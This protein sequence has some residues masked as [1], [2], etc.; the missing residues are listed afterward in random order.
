M[1]LALGSL[2]PSFKLVTYGLS[3]QLA[4]NGLSPPYHLNKSTVILGASGMMFQF[5]GVT[6]WATLFAHV[7]VVRPGSTQTNLIVC[8]GSID[9]EAACDERGP[10]ILS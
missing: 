8:D 1:R 7:A 3:L 9:S 2:A 5:C 10:Y 4:T 6:T